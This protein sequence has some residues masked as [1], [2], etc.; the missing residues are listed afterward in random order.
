MQKRQRTEALKKT[1]EDEA[2]YEHHHEPTSEAESL[3][4]I[5]VS[6][7]LR[8]CDKVIKIEEPTIASSFEEQSTITELCDNM[9]KEEIEEEGSAAKVDNLVKLI[10][11]TYSKVRYYC[12]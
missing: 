12:R 11:D 4:P 1:L 2:K 10:V 6:P 7:S 8:Q 3:S 5:L 9:E